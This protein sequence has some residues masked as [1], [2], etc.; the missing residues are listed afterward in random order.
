MVVFSQLVKIFPRCFHS[1][2]VAASIRTPTEHLIPSRH[3]NPTTFL[4]SLVS[5]RLMSTDFYTAPASSFAEK[6]GNADALVIVAHDAAK[7]ADADLKRALQTY[8]EIN[9]RLEKEVSVIR[10]DKAPFRLIYSPTGPLNRDY[11]DVRRVF[12]AANKVCCCIA[13]TVKGQIFAKVPCRVCCVV[14]GL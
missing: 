9:N 14:F 3:L 13:Y 5:K 7:I 6:A 10:M 8:G 4:C 2:S 11:D 1:I 12:D